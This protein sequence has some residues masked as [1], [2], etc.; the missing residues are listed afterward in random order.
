MAESKQ[1]TSQ[2]AGHLADD[3]DDEE[4]EQRG[5]V[6]GTAEAE[7]EEEKKTESKEEEEEEDKSGE[8]QEEELEDKALT[9]GDAHEPDAQ[10]EEEEKVEDAGETAGSINQEDSVKDECASSDI[11][12]ERVCLE[13]STLKSNQPSPISEG[14][15]D[16]TN[17][18]DN[19]RTLPSPDVSSP[20]PEPAPLSPQCEPS[21]EKVPDSFPSRQVMLDKD[22]SEEK[23]QQEN[24]SSDD[25]GDDED[26]D[27]NDNEEE[28]GEETKEI[29][30]QPTSPE[31]PKLPPIVPPTH[32]PEV[33][34]AP[35]KVS[36][37]PVA[38]EEPSS[39]SSASEGGEEEGEGEES[40]A[41]IGDL[42]SE[43]NY[44]DFSNDS[45]VEETLGASQ[46]IED[47]LAKELQN[48][49]EQMD[50]STTGEMASEQLA[51]R[52]SLAM[53]SVDTPTSTP[54]HPSPSCN[55][56]TGVYPTQP[57]SINNMQNTNLNNNGFGAVEIDVT[58]LGLESPTSISSNE[59]PNTSV[60]SAPTPCTPNFSDCAQIQN[61]IGNS[62]GSFM[63]TVGVPS[64]PLPAN[65]AGPIPNNYNMPPAAPTPNNY[66]SPVTTYQPVLLQQNTHRLTHNNTPCNLP[67]QPLPYQTNASSCSLAK[68]QQLTNGINIMEILPENTMTPPPNLTPPPNMTPPPAVLRNI[69]TPPI[70][71]LQPQISLAQQ[72]KSYQRR[73]NAAMRKSPSVNAG[74][75]FTP[76]VTIQPGSNVITRCNVLNGYRMQQPMLNHGYIPNAG[77]MNQQQ[78]S[79]MQMSVVHQANF[80]QQMQPAQPNN[81][82]YTYGYI[83]GGLSTHTLNM[84]NMMRR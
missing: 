5:E 26:D 65:S 1:N 16:L 13:D 7:E 28:T 61:Y 41:A 82:V 68:L 54:N 2:N 22:G 73:Q 19:I 72:Y 29:S 39:P 3:E 53:N 14:P 56:V 67:R 74:M 47:A 75:T 15:P 32:Q 24:S 76:N 79:P 4:D 78:F 43:E 49:F 59:M 38:V 31:D 30:I 27:D 50:N 77:F 66:C 70:P 25:D 9:N 21:E 69:A 63:D 58:Q 46:N 64:M 37:K 40:A 17:D 6:N 12:Q 34:G 8:V 20:A 52:D 45:T 36:E 35:D 48:N 55:S 84:N 71:N 51:H 62:S 60:E 42:P 44:N 11:E 81:A 80:Q 10:E 18:S 23:A 57:N 33:A 83:N